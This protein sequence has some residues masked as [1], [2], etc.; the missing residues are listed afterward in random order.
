MSRRDPLDF[1]AIGR[2]LAE[3][4]GPTYWRSLEELAEDPSFVAFCEAEFPSVAPQLDRRRFLQLMGASLAFGGL[5]A[6]G[7]APETAVPYVEQPE[8][9]VPGET[10]LY[11]TAV[12]FAGYLQPVLAAPRPAARPSWRVIPTIRPAEVRPARSPR[13]RSSSCTTR[14]A[15]RRPATRAVMRP[16]R[17][18]SARPPAGVNVGMPAP[19]RACTCCLAPAA[20]RPWRV[21]WSAGSRAGHRHGCIASSPTR[22][23]VTP[24]PSRPSAGRWSATCTWKRLNCC[25]VSR[26][27]CSAAA[28]SRCCTP[29]AG[30][31]AV[32]RP[33]KAAARPC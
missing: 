17:P 29:A 31:S 18:F 2:R 6:C 25:C 1:A 8:L 11:A 26:T 3:E 5:A 30:A 7:K 19:V 33:P 21:S 28:R 16:G 20:R 22:G 12:D 9:I 15:R 27:T 23:A 14:T 10:R 24:P 13:R 32:A 4:R